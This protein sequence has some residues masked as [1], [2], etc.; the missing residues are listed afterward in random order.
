MLKDT[1]I[2]IANLHVI[3]LRL[4]KKH[5]KNNEPLTYQYVF[6][7]YHFPATRQVLWPWTVVRDSEDYWTLNFPN[8]Y[9]ESMGSQCLPEHMIRQSYFLPCVCSDK[10]WRVIVLWF[11]QW[12]DYKFSLTVFFYSVG[13]YTNNSKIHVYTA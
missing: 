2:L 6:P 8:A 13:I 1:I 5:N 7:L 12:C 11:F 10:H 4:S 9:R 3:Y